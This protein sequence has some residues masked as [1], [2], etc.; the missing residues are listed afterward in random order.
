MRG[1]WRASALLAL[2]MLVLTTTALAGLSL[3]GTL[4]RY[5]PN[6][7]RPLPESGDKVYIYS[8]RTG[9]IGP[10]ITDDY[11]RYAFYDLALQGPYVMRVYAD[12]REV[13]EQDV[14]VP[15]TVAPIVLGGN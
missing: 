13:W 2:L 6:G 7:P 14:S 11:G 9:W 15:G 12:D 1:L 10:S 8:S 4:L 5:N 3:N